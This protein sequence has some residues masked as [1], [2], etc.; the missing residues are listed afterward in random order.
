MPVVKR[1]ANPLRAAILRT[2][3]RVDAP[4]RDRTTE[5][6][7]LRGFLAGILGG[8]VAD[9]VAPEA[10]DAMMQAAMPAMAFMPG[11]R[12][13]HPLLK[14][15][16]PEQLKRMIDQGYDVEN[17]LFHGT[18]KRHATSTLTPVPSRELWSTRIPLDGP[19]GFDH[20]QPSRL[21]VDGDGVYLTNTAEEAGG[22][23]RHGTIYPVVTRG[24]LAADVRPH[25]E[26]SMGYSSHPSPAQTDRINLSGRPG[27]DWRH[28]DAPPKWEG[29]STH[30][31]VKDPKN[32]RSIFA[33]FDPNKMELRDLL[34]SILGVGAAS[35]LL[36]R[37]DP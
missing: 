21:G 31:I 36:P 25:P 37:K 3:N 15:H 7:Q 11:G 26:L 12:N 18:P 16:S 17:V 27:T 13:I 35:T 32:I 23:G 1:P 19:K 6:A 29:V 5:E 22:Y 8:P 9:T 20:I 4:T 14:N 34:A 28:P 10:E 33:N 2:A 24:S 30:Q